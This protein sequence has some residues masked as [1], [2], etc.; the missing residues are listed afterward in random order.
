VVYYGDKVLGHSSSER[1]AH[2]VV[3]GI[4]NEIFYNVLFDGYLFIP[5]FIVQ[6]NWTHNFKIVN[7]LFIS[8]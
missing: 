4:L 3:N 5:Y 6:H 2:I 7:G 8:T 1:L